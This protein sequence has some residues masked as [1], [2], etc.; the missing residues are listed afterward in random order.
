MQT[1][2]LPGPLQQGMMP[3]PH[4]KPAETASCGNLNKAGGQL[5]GRGTSTPSEA[6]Q[7]QSALEQP[8]KSPGPLMRSLSVLR[9]LCL[10][11]CLLI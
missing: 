8:C 5:K 4:G 10:E 6:V 1:P 7:N 11:T 9:K 3:H 2:Q